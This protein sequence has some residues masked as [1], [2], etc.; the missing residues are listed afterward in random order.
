[1]PRINAQQLDRRLEKLEAMGEAPASHV[2]IVSFGDDALD[3]QI[4]S[5]GIEY[6]RIDGEDDATFRESVL[7]ERRLNIHSPIVLVK[8]WAL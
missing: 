7:S 8:R 6:H 3:Y 1:M 2:I 4:A 5:Q